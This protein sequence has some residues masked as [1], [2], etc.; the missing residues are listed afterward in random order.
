MLKF[1][2]LQSLWESIERYDKERADQLDEQV[3]QDALFKIT[4]NEYALYKEES[5]K[6]IFA[7]YPEIKELTYIYNFDDF[8]EW[9]IDFIANGEDLAI[10]GMASKIIIECAE[11]QNYITDCFHERTEF[12][13]R[14]FEAEDIDKEF[15]SIVKNLIGEVI[16]GEM[17][18]IIQN[19]QANNKYNLCTEF[20]KMAV[21]EYENTIAE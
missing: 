9:E 1:F 13:E 11:V 17:Q 16:A 6:E 2:T 8:I 12:Y 19:I 20:I 7:K 3:K 5:E 14:I 21:K 4:E 18:S 10:K 15:Q